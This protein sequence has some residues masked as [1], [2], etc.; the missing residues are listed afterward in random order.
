MTDLQWLIERPISHRG[1]H[2]RANGIIENSLSAIQCAVEKHYAIEV[3]LQMT[4]DH[5]A[6]V[7]HDDN[8][9]RLTNESGMV[10]SHPR[11]ELLQIPLKET[12]DRIWS[13]E[14]LLEEVNGK[15]TLVV[16]LKS[17]N[18]TDRQIAYL[19]QVAKIISTYK[20]P[21]A[22]KSFDPHMLRAM[23][24]LA[25]NIPRGILSMSRPGEEERTRLGPI[26][27]KL[28]PSLLH[29]LGTKPQFISYGVDDLPAVVPSL[30]KRFFKMPL[31]TW[32]V[33]TSQQR[34]IADQYA[35]QMIFEGF[36]PDQTKTN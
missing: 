26:L 9:D 30:L 18:R 1:Y 35:D 8:L 2:N 19:T 29:M 13:L 5:Q 28:M 21:L 25:P 14:N 31:M 16:E 15:Q 7:F 23:A 27:S 12:T 24:H 17:L 33:R 20:G 3:D 6:V 32:T 36:D 4:N 22:V 11:H 34:Q 10:M